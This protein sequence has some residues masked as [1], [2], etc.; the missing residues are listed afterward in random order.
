MYRREF[1]LAGLS[2]GLAARSLHGSE[3]F[4]APPAGASKVNVDIDSKHLQWLRTADEVADALIDMNFDG[5]KL[6]V[7]PYP[8]HIEPA[9][10]AAELPAFVGAI[11]KK[12]IR[13]ASIRTS[14]VD[15]DTPHAEE[16][17]R[18]ASSAG[19]THYEI[20]PI[21]YEAGQPPMAQLDALKPRFVKIA[22]LSA[23]YH[24]TALINTSGTDS[25]GAASWDL[26]RA[27]QEVDPAQI[28]ILYDV[29][30][31][32]RSSSW[33]LNLRSASRHI[34]AVAVRDFV[35]EQDLGLKGGGGEYTPPPAGSQPAGGGRGGGRVAG[36]GG[37][38]RGGRGNTV[39][40]PVV[41]GLPNGWKIQPVPLGTGMVN[42]RQ[43]AV[44]LKE[45]DF[46]GPVEIDVD[47]PIGGANDGQ[48]KISLPR[49]QVLGAMKRDLLA[50][51][52][53]FNRA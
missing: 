27:L 7:L 36:P 13:V 28:G 41:P 2:A 25:V 16:I 15:A 26:V 9:K 20:G 24:M 52:T 17:L 39:S 47:Y 29:L 10:T 23:K 43:L 35:Y 33:E 38:P 37:P 22:A 30:Q 44:V 51:R 34:R 5:L 49:A 42:L 45:I 19:V 4:Q 3:I 53:A 12:G 40:T 46:T 11:R 18:A 14:I 31:Q 6:A 8:G 1:L 50:L 32:T 48:D 21:R